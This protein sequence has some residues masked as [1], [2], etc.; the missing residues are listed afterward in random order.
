MA[1]GELASTGPP[2]GQWTFVAKSCAAPTKEEADQGN[3]TVLQSADGRRLGVYVGHERVT[4]WRVALDD[5]DAPR[6]RPVTFQ[7]LPESAATGSCRVLGGSVRPHQINPAMTL[8]YDGQFTID[9]TSPQG[10]T[11]RGA[12]RFENCPSAL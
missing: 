5:L 2:L 1:S 10:G 9:C 3:F 8:S 12:I 7:E 6:S 4:G 11:V